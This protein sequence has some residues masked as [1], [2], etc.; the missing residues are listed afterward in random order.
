MVLEFIK[1]Y[2]LHL[3]NLHAQLR[4]GVPIQDLR[5]CRIINTPAKRV[6]TINQ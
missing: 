5:Y 3:G 1:Q 6:I 4:P 2:L